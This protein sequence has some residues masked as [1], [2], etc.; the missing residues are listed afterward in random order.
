VIFLRVEIKDSGINQYRQ[1]GDYLWL[2]DP[3]II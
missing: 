1:V 3:N 2:V